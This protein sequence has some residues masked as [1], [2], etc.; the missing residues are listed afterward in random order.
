M[1][2]VSLGE[3]RGAAKAYL[4]LKCNGNYISIA[5]TEGCLGLHSLRALSLL[6]QTGSGLEFG[7]VTTCGTGSSDFFC[8]GRCVC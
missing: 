2:K 7:L 5:S 8:T 6:S 1:T 4:L 3:V